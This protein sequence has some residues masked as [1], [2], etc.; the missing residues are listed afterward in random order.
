VTDTTALLADPSLPPPAAGLLR[1]RTLGDVGL[2]YVVEGRVTGTLGVGKPL[3]LV[4]YLA[5]SPRRAESRDHLV[6]LLWSDVETD[7]ARHALRQ[8][9]WYLKRRL[10]DPI[11]SSE[12]DRI[13]LLPAVAF[14][15]DAFLNAVQRVDWTAADACYRG[16]FFAGFAAP[17]GAEFEHWAEAE[18]QR[19]RSAWMR[20][21]EGLVGAHVSAGR[22]RDAQAAARRLR[23]AEPL[24][25]A[26]WRLLIEALL[27]GRDQLGATLECDALTALLA[28][29]EIDADAPTRR[30]L[31][32]VSQTVASGELSTN[33]VATDLI[34]RE[35]E[36]A[37]LLSHWEDARA[38]RTQVVALLGGA[39]IG[40]SR[41][42]VDLAARLKAARARVVT[43]RASSAATDIGYSFAAEVVGALTQAPGALAVPEGVAGTLLSINPAVA[44]VYPR[45]QPDGA[46]G[47]DALRR[48]VV[49]LRE[50]L[51]VVSEE[52]P[53]A[54]LL[55]DLHW[56]DPSTRR[57]LA[58]ALAGLSSSRVLLVVTSRVPVREFETLSTSIMRL[59]PL[60]AD[61]V[62]TL[63]ASI[64]RL[65]AEP[66]SDALVAGLHDASE[67]VPLLLLETVQLALERGAL[68]IP[69][70]VW[71]LRDETGLRALLQGDS[72][73]VRRIESLDDT[74]RRLLLLLA[75]AAVPMAMDAI[76]S[77]L[78]DSSA[79][80]VRL[81]GLEERGLVVREDARWRIVHDEYGASLQRSASADDVRA[82][83][84][85]IGRAALH[86]AHSARD[87]RLEARAIVHLLAG[88]ELAPL[89]G[90]L[91]RRVEQARRARE[92]RSTRAIVRETLGGDVSDATLDD[93]VRRV[94]L[95]VRV[96]L[97]TRPRSAA[98]LGLVAVVV[99]AM[100]GITR[101][102]AAAPAPPAV[103]TLAV[104]IGN[105][106]GSGLH[107]H[108][109]PIP[110]VGADGMITL[111]KTPAATLP[112]LN[113]RHFSSA[114]PTANGWVL[115]RVSRD[116]GG[117]DL[118]EHQLDGTERRL[119]S[120]IADE[121][122]PS[123]S[124]D[125]RFLLYSSG[126]FD[127]ITDHDDV[128]VMERATGAMRRL[129][130]RLSIDNGPRWSLDGS[131]IAYMS[132]DFERPGMAV[133]VLDSDGTHER[134]HQVG[135][136][137]QLVG[138]VDATHLLFLASGSAVG[139]L[140]YLDIDNGQV[141]D[142]DLEATFASLSPDG[143]WM[144]CRCLVGGYGDAEWWLAPSHDLGGKRLLRIAGHDPATLNIN[145]MPGNARARYLKRLA[146]RAPSFA[147]PA[148]SSFALAVDAVDAQGETVRGLSIRWQSS[149]SA[150]AS[151][152]SLGVLHAHRPGRVR[153]T[154][155]AGGWRTSTSDV[156]V[157]A[158][159][160]STVALHE[161]WGADW[162]DRWVSYG[163]PRPYVRDRS[164]AAWLFPNGDKQFSSGVVTREAYAVETGISVSAEL[165]NPIAKP[166]WQ[167]VG[168]YL[169]AY[170]PPKSLQS[171][172]QP[173]GDPPP[174]E[175]SDAQCAV[176]YPGD[177][178]G[179]G[180]G[181]SVVLTGGGRS[182]V[183]SAP[184]TA[185]MRAG[186]PFHVILSLL[187]D[188]R[189]EARV[190]DQ[191]VL[192]APPSARIDVTLS[193]HVGIQGQSQW[194]PN[195]VGPLTLSR[196]TREPRR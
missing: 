134:C 176:T 160:A 65:P 188:G 51:A 132:R 139:R 184:A 39:G 33:A 47:D 155:T 53:V 50:L 143:N 6:D 123:L 27:A 98:V 10:G 178:E 28:R 42:L 106:D 137:H 8:T 128:V 125:G 116:S 161:T 49:A 118:Y 61:D 186:Q 81:R 92:L 96:G 91:A 44:A 78:P 177:S 89:G 110:D 52:Q 136:L 174:S 57:L 75:V 12:G 158:T 55:D 105:A 79:I 114:A 109:A 45:A 88:G 154:A 74:D 3:A 14:D 147:V 80:D 144:L 68:A 170:R 5:C 59:E 16:D 173:G 18:R 19:L 165:T 189:C 192:A 20:C 77:I 34:G 129:T 73:I 41:L 99:L 190:N 133:C 167:Q 90:V 56:S 149:D 156:T 172:M 85:A 142:S 24:R 67:G 95:L 94:P 31:R 86:E 193:Y 4:A 66:W 141:R 121:N 100:A 102:P 26:S 23:D 168:L 164:G 30:V 60:R 151:V 69:D 82:M 7:A 148:A 122:A 62:A 182:S 194:T 157:G 83:H 35:R 97:V 32:S 71:Q 150:V 112:P 117:V 43:V 145:W 46:S 11:L 130:Q 15:R 169:L 183:T 103:P 40:K 152:D 64:A 101:E 135:M 107:I 166:Q 2:E 195:A 108:A 185:A 191:L 36:F 70:G 111:S 153:I 162:T 181:N 63:L 119:T 187:P 25:Q 140:K 175:T 163:T 124:P 13:V 126:Q 115:M 127:R 196:G 37:E 113:S 21:L 58:A 72:A 179:Y 120:D 180:Y 48:R 87:E 22:F 138:W 29:E 84:A 38:G 146:L 171:A 93:L 76:V 1:L 131:R 17:G 159:R 9:V 104:A 54:L